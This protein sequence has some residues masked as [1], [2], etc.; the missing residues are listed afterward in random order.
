MSY[1]PQGILQRIAQLHV[2]EVARALGLS[3]TK[4]ETRCFMHDDRRPS[5]KFHK[6]GHLWK[7]FVCDKGG[8]PVHLVM[9]YFKMDYIDACLWLC[10]QF[11]IYVP[12][13][14][15]HNRILRP[16]KKYNTEKQVES[17]F[18]REIG[19]WLI[20]NARLSQEAQRFLFD[21]RKLS[22]EIVLQSNIKSLSDSRKLI[23]ALSSCFTDDELVE[24]GYLKINGDKKYLRLF[25]PCLLFPYYDT[26]CN[27]I[28]IQSRYMGDNG[29]APRFQ[30]VSGFK[31]SIYNQQIVKGMNVGD[32]LYISEGVTDCLA[33]LSSGYKTIAIPSASN[34]PVVEMRKLCRFNLIMSVDRDEAGERAYDTLS[35]Q[36][37]KMGGRIRRLDY[38]I[39]FKD[40]GEYYKSGR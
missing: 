22:I 20:S 17:T 24:A 13:A 31:P 34:L 16:L 37:V 23:D 32:D 38:P 9:Y 29:E 35:Y 18:D 33:L 39:K 4:H 19:D 30:F 40:Y 28:G 5:L 21:E 7:C 36:I 26:Q 11:G 12:D 27:L 25:V 6:N 8:G 14:P 15:R 10:R 3:V 2:E 1:L